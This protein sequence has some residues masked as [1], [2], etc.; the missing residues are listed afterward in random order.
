[1]K[2]RNAKYLLVEKKLPLKKTDV[3]KTW[4]FSVQKICRQVS[5]G[6]LQLA[7]ISLNF[8]TSCCNLKISGL[9]AELYVDFLF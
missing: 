8:K 2:K 6:E 4:I 9:G 7:Q 1:M 5:F 3:L